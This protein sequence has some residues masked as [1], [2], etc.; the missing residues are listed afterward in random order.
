MVAH[1]FPPLV[2]GVETHTY[3]L[4][5]RV[6]ADPQ[7]QVGVLTTDLA[8]ELPPYEVMEGVHV[9]RVPAWPRG[10]DLYVAPEIYRRV[11]RASVDIVHCQGYHTFVPPLAIRAAGQA[12]T[13]YLLTLHSGGHSSRVRRAVRPIQLRLLH[14]QLAGAKRLI[15]VSRFEADLFSRR[16]RL[17]PDRFSVIPN[18]ADIPAA[19]PTGV[20]GP[21]DPD[22]I[23]SVGRLERYKGHHRLI[24][25]LPFVRRS[26]PRARLLIL[27]SG[28][29]EARLRQLAEESG[30]GDA[31]DIRVVPRED[32]PVAMRRSPVVALL[33][34][35]ESQG[36][37]VH[38]AL[39][40]G[41]RVVVTD[42]SALA[43]LSD[44][45]Q[46]ATVPSA[47]GPAEVAHA[48]VAQLDAPA[49]ALTDLPRLSTW[50]DCA[51]QNMEL[52]RAVVSAVD[53]E[54]PASS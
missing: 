13:P 23:L 48:L 24:E 36:L 28:P 7:F 12:G 9:H 44:L 10:S 33:S 19:E 53:S 16:L 17:P 32:L 40:L 26:H 38:E 29:H 8:G 15:A 34:E 46:V 2:G 37:A 27:G 35:Y 21:R 54:I 52:Y 42:G 50:D 1:R 47:A 41:C 4:S 18:G 11:R 43:E 22:L 30:L 25:A 3:E 51:R 45:P 6:A 20:G 14:R 49:A 31:V 5:R 39:A